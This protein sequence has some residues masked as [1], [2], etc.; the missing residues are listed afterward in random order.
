MPYVGQKVHSDS[1]KRDAAR[2]TICLGRAPHQRLDRYVIHVRARKSFAGNLTGWGPVQSLKKHRSHAIV[3]PPLGLE[4]RPF[5]AGG[6]TGLHRHDTRAGVFLDAFCKP[7]RFSRPHD[8][9]CM[10]TLWV[11]TP[12]KNGAPTP[13]TLGGETFLDGASAAPQNPPPSTNQR[14]VLGSFLRARL[15]LSTSPLLSLIS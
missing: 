11:G 4:C 12:R 7:L 13:G 9:R 8:P 1:S 3:V 2:R 15:C 14:R 6:V 5:T 10:W